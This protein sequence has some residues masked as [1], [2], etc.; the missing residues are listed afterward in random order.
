L[1]TPARTFS[2]IGQKKP[3]PFQASDKNPV[4]FPRLGKLNRQAGGQPKDSC[5]RHKTP[6][7]KY[8][9]PG[10]KCDIPGWKSDFPSQ[11]NHFPS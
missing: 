5:S 10:W 9:I 6:G 3:A 8:E 11:E 7:W 4:F 1:E 2:T